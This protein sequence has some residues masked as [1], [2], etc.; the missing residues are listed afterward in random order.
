MLGFIKKEGIMEN[1]SG[2]ILIEDVGII[3]D[4]PYHVKVFYISVKVV[5]VPTERE[6]F[7]VSG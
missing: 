3:D 7:I 4:G 5:C 6:D 2:V 1:F